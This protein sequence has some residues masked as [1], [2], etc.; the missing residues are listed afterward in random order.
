MI[1]AAMLTVAVARSGAEV[2][3]DSNLTTAEAGAPVA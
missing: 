1:G 3:D 2:V